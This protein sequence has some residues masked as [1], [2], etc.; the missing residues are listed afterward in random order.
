MTRIFNF[1]AYSIRCFAEDANYPELGCHE[2]SM[3][4]ESSL[5]LH[6]R[7]RTWSVRWDIGRIFSIS[8]L[9]YV[10]TE[11]EINRINH[12][13]CIRSVYPSVDSLS[14]KA[15]AYKEQMG[16]LNILTIGTI[17]QE[18][19]RWLELCS[20]QP[21]VYTSLTSHRIW[22]TAQYWHNP[23]QRHRENL[24]LNQQKSL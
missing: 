24:E 1:R 12:G 18:S 23:Y 14:T 17:I 7:V 8:R 10:G 9:K 13:S 21:C 15:V 22:L 20:P 11:A 3:R 6:G 19:I 2:N 16:I 4:R 5:K